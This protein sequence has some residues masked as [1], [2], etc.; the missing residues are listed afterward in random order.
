[1]AADD[2]AFSPRPEQ[3]PQPGPW[4][5]ELRGALDDRSLV[6]AAIRRA[7]SIPAM[8]GAVRKTRGASAPQPGQP[9]GASKADMG[10]SA[11]NV[12]QSSQE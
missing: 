3:H 10:R 4:L 9:H 5:F 7:G 2:G 6:A 11:V 12:P 1:M 8:A